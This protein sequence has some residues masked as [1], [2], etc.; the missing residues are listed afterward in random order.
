MIENCLLQNCLLKG[1]PCKTWCNKILKNITNSTW[2]LLNILV[3]DSL[4]NTLLCHRSCVSSIWSLFYHNILAFKH[5][6]LPTTLLFYHGI[7][8]Y[9]HIYD[10]YSISL[11]GDEY[12]AGKP[13]ITI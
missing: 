11:F 1:Q 7:Y 12:L 13:T 2:K 9:I 5:V 10:S 6:S 3:L 4:S 8:F